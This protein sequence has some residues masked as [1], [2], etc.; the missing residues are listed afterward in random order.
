MNNHQGDTEGDNKQ[1]RGLKD[2]EKH[3]TGYEGGGCDPIMGGVG[4]GGRWLWLCLGFS[5]FLEWPVHMKGWPP[6]RATSVDTG[7]LT[8]SVCAAGWKEDGRP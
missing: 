8:I 1:A 3:P 7:L 5:W 6:T 2:Y 4:G